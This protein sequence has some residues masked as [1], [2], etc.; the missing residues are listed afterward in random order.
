MGVNKKKLQQQL[1][2]ETGKAVVMKDLSNIALSAKRERHGTRNDLSKCVDMLRTKYNCT[3]DISTDEEDN[4]CG[5]FIQD[6]E[7]TETFQAFPEIIFLDATYKLLDLQFPVYLFVS[8]DSN[9]LSEVVGM[10]MLVTEDAASLSW[11]VETFKLKNPA[12]ER[13]RLVMADKDLNER[14]TI[15]VVLPHVKVLI[16]LFHTLR[17]FR[18]E[19]TTEK[20][21]ITN[22][23][24]ISCVEYIQRMAYAKT[25]HEYTGIYDEF[26]TIA[27]EDVKSYFDKNWH[28]IKEEWVMGFKFST[29]NFLNSTNNRLEAINGKLKHLIDRNSSLEYFTE[30]F[31]AILS[32]LRNERSY[33]TVYSY[34]KVKVVPHAINSPEAQYSDLLTSY[35]SGYTLQQ[36]KIARDHV[37][38]FTEEAGSVGNFTTSTSEGVVTVSHFRC[39]CCY[40]QSMRLPCRHMFALRQHSGISLYDKNLCDE[41]W[42]NS[43]YRSAHKALR[44]SETGD[45]LMI[46]G[47]DDTVTVDISTQSRAKNLNCHQKFSK[48]LDICKK[49]ANTISY[50]SQVDFD[51]KLLQL[52]SL[53]ETWLGGKEVGIQVFASLLEVQSRELTRCSHES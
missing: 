35:A 37:Y 29:G 33:K 39:T 30:S 38:E 32:V 48:A 31:F 20:M 11:L 46:H 45:D 12:V 1:S 24:R 51:R 16:C 41:R 19:V 7:M 17:T 3:V 21:N 14:D 50:C 40:F 47:E 36:L 23:Q 13:T 8:E 18:R 26:A 2:T 49:I 28:P 6:R 25:D 22:A 42:T 15:K 4:F 34:Q 52:K 5:L 9:G 27:P 53:N 10:G 43:Y 44:P